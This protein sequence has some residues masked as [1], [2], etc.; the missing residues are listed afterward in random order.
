MKIGNLDFKSFAAKKPLMITSEGRFITAQQVAEAPSLGQGSPFALEEKL[1]IEL[2]V[3]RYSLE[4]DFK[5]GIIDGGLYSKDDIIDHIERR[6]EFGQLVLKTE[7]GYCD[8]LSSNLKW[9]KVPPWPKKPPK[10][11]P[12][13]PWWKRKDQCIWLR[14]RN[15]ALFYDRRRHDTDRQLAHC[16]CSS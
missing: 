12:Q 11:I 6:T 1:Q 2:A 9:E 4:P 15:R 10:P 16:E 13:P 14:V 8:Q 5:L 3:K 7:M